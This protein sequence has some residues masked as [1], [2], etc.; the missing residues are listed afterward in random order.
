MSGRRWN[1]CWID[2]GVATMRKAATKAIVLLACCAPLPGC[3]YLMGPADA[4]FRVS[5]ELPPSTEGP[6]LLR[7]HA[8]P[9][10][11]VM[12]TQPVSGAFEVPFIYYAAARAKGFRFEL[13]CAQSPWV[14]V[15]DQVN[16]KKPRPPIYP[17]GRISP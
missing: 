14:A 9:S 8:L 17:L 2:L 7:M 10:Q 6:C 13:S 5:G 15:G 11:V 1:R 3:I 12:S 16:L 4:V